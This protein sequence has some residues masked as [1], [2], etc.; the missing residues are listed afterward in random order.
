MAWRAVPEG[1]H[2]NL[3][4][5]K[6]LKATYFTTEPRRQVGSGKLTGQSKE[7]GENSM[8]GAL[9][10]DHGSEDLFSFFNY[11]CDSLTYR[12]LPHLPSLGNATQTPNKVCRLRFLVYRTLFHEPSFHKRLTYLVPRFTLIVCTI[13]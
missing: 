4:S 7:E 9:C 5:K 10:H 8:Q 13:K 12:G 11:C 2:T 3:I 1:L 6:K